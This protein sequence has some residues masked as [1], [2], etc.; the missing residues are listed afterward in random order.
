MQVETYLKHNSWNAP[1][2]EKENIQVQESESPKA[3][4]TQRENVK[5]DCNS[6]GKKLKTKNLKSNKGK[7][8][9]V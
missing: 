2:L 5:A 4:S 8:S 6:K 1:N 3:A 7:T 9:N